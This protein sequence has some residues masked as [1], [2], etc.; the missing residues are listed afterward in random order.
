MTPPLRSA[1]AT[2][3]F[4]LEVM[5]IPA[6]LSGQPATPTILSFSN[7]AK[8]LKVST[9]AFGDLKPVAHYMPETSFMK[10]KLGPTRTCP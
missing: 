9:E 6:L 10:G 8:D 2:A 5:N 1:E 3:H 7:F 4:T